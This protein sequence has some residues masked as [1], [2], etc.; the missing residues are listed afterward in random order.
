MFYMRAVFLILVLCLSCNAQEKQFV[1]IGCFNIEWFPCKEDGEMMKNYGINLRTPPTGSATDMEALFKLLT[2]LDIELLGVVEIVDPMLLEKEAQTRLGSQ[3]KVIY[4][5]DNGSQKVGFLY[6]SS[7]LQIVG[8]PEIYSDLK[9]D[10]DSWNRPA[11]RAFFKYKEDGFDFH[12]II[13]HLKASPSGLKLR[14]KQW[15]LLG[16]ILTD[17]P[18][19]YGDEDIIL[20]GDF[21]NVS[22]YGADEFIPLIDSLNYYW[23]TSVLSDS[24]FSNYWQPDY[25]IERI[26]GSLIDHIFISNNAKYEYKN[27]SLRVGGMCH[28]GQA[29]YLGNDIPDFYKGIS[30]H[31]PVYGSF[32][33]DIDND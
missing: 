33:A 3:Y 14:K 26:Q 8:Q 25:S 2:K 28:Q 27:K 10:P 15:D 4:A 29:E 22:K 23:A 31:C 11:L 13:V 30:D 18:Q 6:D 24:G 16:K 32:R 21:N 7:V 1:E 9:L 12:A 19:K 20:M 17:I 5:P